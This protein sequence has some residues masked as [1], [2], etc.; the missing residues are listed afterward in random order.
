MTEEDKI[1]S[2]KGYEGLVKLAEE[3]IKREDTFVSCRNKLGI[4]AVDRLKVLRR[5]R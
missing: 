1:N 5:I 4:K 3:E 2:K